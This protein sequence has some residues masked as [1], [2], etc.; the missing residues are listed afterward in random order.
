[1][2]ANITGISSLPPDSRQ[3]YAPTEEPS[4]QPRRKLDSNEQQKFFVVIES[5]FRLVNQYQNALESQRPGMTPTS[6]DNT[7]TTR[8]LKEKYNKL[9]PQIKQYLENYKNAL[10]NL[11][12]LLQIKREQIEI[13]WNGPNKGYLDLSSSSFGITYC[14]SE[15]ERTLAKRKITIKSL[16]DERKFFKIVSDDSPGEQKRGAI[17]KK[18]VDKIESEDDIGEQKR[19]VSEEKEQEQITKGRVSKNKLRLRNFDPAEFGP[20]L[21]LDIPP[22]LCRE[23]KEFHGNWFCSI[24][25]VQTC[26]RLKAELDVL[27]EINNS[28]GTNNSFI[29][30]FQLKQFQQIRDKTKAINTLYVHRKDAGYG[31]TTKW[32]SPLLHKLD[33][34]YDLKRQEVTARLQKIN[35]KIEN[36]P[37]LMNAGK[38]CSEEKNKYTEAFNSLDEEAEVRLAEITILELLERV[39]Q[40]KEMLNID[41]A[42]EGDLNEKLRIDLYQFRQKQVKKLK[43]SIELFNQYEEG[44]P[45]KIP[46]RARLISVID[47]QIQFNQ[48]WL[49]RISEIN[50][51]YQEKTCLIESKIKF[52]ESKIK[53]QDKENDG[54]NI[55]DQET[56]PSTHRK[57]GF[58]GLW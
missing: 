38:A 14:L 9:N 42:F 56:P 33:S 22:S 24:K 21:P 50:Q 47:A 37:L 13:C 53:S 27:E 25:A 23:I 46:L 18:K 3:Y 7:E 15:I 44:D 58:L 8:K 6:L 34:L 10:S 26:V 39:V 55:K 45:D 57:R 40:F 35:E 28:I 2:E 17:N 36:S 16:L 43:D 30:F 5:F 48:D 52:I 29:A 19:W 12:V 49:K 32:E 1:M 51:E 20:L 41:E 11:N 31:F 54:P 4:H